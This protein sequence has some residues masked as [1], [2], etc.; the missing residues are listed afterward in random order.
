ML[1][2]RAVIKAIV[3]GGALVGTG[4]LMPRLAMAQWNKAAFVAVSQ[5]A[6]IK[7]LLGGKP[8][9][10][11]QVVLQAPGNAADGTLVPVTVK[12]SLVNVESISL[13][14]EANLNPLV[15][16]FIIPEGTEPSVST[17]IRIYTSSAITA[18]VKA[19]GLL[20]SNSQET[21]VTIGGC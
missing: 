11:D 21:K 2:R 1:N 12:T 16:E 18:V 5:A 17:R 9:A 15:A 6:A 14:V 20:L 7:A 13:F 3:A 10:S 4:V 19:D 8:V